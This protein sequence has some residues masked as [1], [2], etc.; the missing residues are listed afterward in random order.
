MTVRGSCLNG[1]LKAHL[2]IAHSAEPGRIAASYPVGSLARL[3]ALQQQQKKKGG[4]SLNCAMERAGWTQFDR[5][6]N[7]DTELEMKC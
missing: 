1:N 3:L 4:A 2:A 7:H 5:R 6:E